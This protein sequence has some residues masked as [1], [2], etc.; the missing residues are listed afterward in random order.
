M[1]QL[2][3]HPTWVELPT[4]SSSSSTLGRRQWSNTHTQR[5]P[6]TLQQLPLNI[7]YAICTP[8]HNGRGVSV[9]VSVCLCVYA[10]LCVFACFGGFRLSGQDEHLNLPTGHLRTLRRSTLPP[11]QPQQQEQHSWRKRKRK[12]GNTAKCLL[13]WEVSLPVPQSQVK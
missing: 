6:E 8:I 9:C 7:I 4:S 12:P 2:N 5:A 10:S 13:F 1:V 3:A 11:K